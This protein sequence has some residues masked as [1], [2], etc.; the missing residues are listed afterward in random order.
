MLS[1]Q[2]LE[3]TGF[4]QF[5]ELMDDGGTCTLYIDRM[6]ERD[7]P[8]LVWHSDSDWDHIIASYSDR[9]LFPLEIELI[10]RFF[11]KPEEQKE[12]DIVPASKDE[13]RPYAVHFWRRNNTHLTG[14]PDAYSHI[15]SALKN[16]PWQ[17]KI[18]PAYHMAV[19]LQSLMVEGSGDAYIKQLEENLSAVYSEPDN[20]SEEDRKFTLSFYKKPSIERFFLM[21]INR[22]EKKL[23][24]SYLQARDTKPKYERGYA[25][26]NEFDPLLH[27]SVIRQANLNRISPQE[28]TDRIASLIESAYAGKDK[29]AEE[30]LRTCFAEKPSIQNVYLQ[31]MLSAEKA[32]YPETTGHKPS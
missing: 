20:L 16:K 7:L 14:T 15:P 1:N 9:F 31:M 19:R 13:P 32:A 21:L 22:A 27:N 17:L 23:Y 2:E 26:K 28:Y 30:T 25:W 12:V 24:P 4:L 5:E 6:P 3:A 10:K 18:N 11:F 29:T 8:L